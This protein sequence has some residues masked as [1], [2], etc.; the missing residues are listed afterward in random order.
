MSLEFGEAMGHIWD[1]RQNPISV[2]RVISAVDPAAL[3][4]AAA[5]W[6]TLVRGACEA[7][8]KSG[9]VA[10]TQAF[11]VLDAPD[12]VEGAVVIKLHESPEEG[13]SGFTNPQVYWKD[14]LEHGALVWIDPDS[15]KGT[16]PDQTKE[17]RAQFI[18]C[19]ELGHVLGLSHRANS[20]MASPGM[21]GLTQT[22]TAEDLDKVKELY[23]TS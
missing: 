16:F 18:V 21:P 17:A 10:F 12:F 23:G 22:P 13:W 6:R 1:P 9:A 8:E 5:D 14:G 19:H 2:I 11:G 4:I 20:I 7:W 3:N 15:T